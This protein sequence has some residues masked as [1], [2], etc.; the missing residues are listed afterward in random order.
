MILHPLVEHVTETVAKHSKEICDEDF[1][2]KVYG[3]ITKCFRFYDEYKYYTSNDEEMNLIVQQEQRL[4][5]SKT[6]RG[7]LMELERHLLDFFISNVTAAD[8]AMNTDELD[9]TND[10][11]TLLDTLRI[12]ET[13]WYSLEITVLSHSMQLH[14]LS[15]ETIKLFK[16]ACSKYDYEK[17]QSSKN[18]LLCGRSWN[19]L[20]AVG[21]PV[22]YGGNSV[23]DDYWTVMYHLALH[24]DL[25]L[26]RDCLYC[27][28]TI[29]SESN[30]LVQ[31]DFYNTFDNHPFAA[32]VNTDIEKDKIDSTLNYYVREQEKWRSYFRHM[33]TAFENNRKFNDIIGHLRNICGILCGD[34]S[35]ILQICRDYIRV[36]SWVTFVMA[37][38]LYQY[39]IPLNFVQIS[40]IVIHARE[41]CAHDASDNKLGDILTHVFSHSSK[42]KGD[43]RELIND[44]LQLASFTPKI[45]VLSSASKLIT[46]FTCTHIIMLLSDEYD[47]INL[48][49]SEE[50]LLEKLLLE[51]LLLLSNAGYP[52]ELICAY[53]HY[54][55]LSMESVEGFVS[56][57]LARRYIHT[58]QDV[59][60]FRKLLLDFFKDEDVEQLKVIVKSIEIARGTY[61]LTKRGVP[62]RLSKAVYFYEL[63]EDN[64]RVIAILDRVICRLMNSVYMDELSFPTLSFGPASPL[65][66]SCRGRAGSTEFIDFDSRNVTDA[67]VMNVEDGERMTL[68]NAIEIAENVLLAISDTSGIHK[69]GYGSSLFRTLDQYVVCIKKCCEKLALDVAPSHLEEAGKELVKLI[70]YNVAPKRFW[71]HI[72]DVAIWCHN[73]YAKFT[74]ERV[75]STDTVKYSIFDKD[76]VY[77]LMVSLESVVNSYTGVDGL[78]NVR[79][80]A[81]VQLK[82]HVKELRL[83]LLGVLTS[84]YMQNSHDSGKNV[85]PKIG[86]SVRTTAHRAYDMLTGTSVKNYL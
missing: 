53:L 36:D 47:I 68:P 4:E 10:L 75:V 42:K 64:D 13:I 67:D 37:S 55:F 48:H 50:R 43:P 21:A 28:E 79:I 71:L 30:F 2:K 14:V 72:I 25:S 82:D 39:A 32:F 44:L 1:M 78:A 63:A 38:L 6:L 16:S 66:Y 33:L 35:I 9:F 5:C 85:Q 70:L 65:G 57:V 22:K 46:S 18:S 23:E 52:L 31:Y 17:L 19:R 61:W 27:N 83:K 3:Y 11:Y 59:S 15:L 34:E 12:M 77:A 24:G 49:V 51:T 73:V 60:M 81:G 26:L 7:C 29:K 80:D 84:S 56:N 86:G 69:D 76:D 62:N 74:R 45:Y 20:S 41:I 58:D 54:N 8:D 40:D